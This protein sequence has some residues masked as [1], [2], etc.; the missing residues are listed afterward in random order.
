M[1]ERRSSRSHGTVKYSGFDDGNESDDDF[2]I[3][4]H[5]TKK[6]KSSKTDEAAKKSN[7][8][9]K[10]KSLN[11][12]RDVVKKHVNTSSQNSAKARRAPLSEKIYERELQEA[13]ELSLVETGES[14]DVVNHGLDNSKPQPPETLTLTADVEITNCGRLA[15][16]S[17]DVSTEPDTQKSSVNTTTQATCSSRYAHGTVVIDESIELA[18]SESG[19]RGTTQ[20]RPT[21]T[22]RDR[23]ARKKP[24]L[25]DK[26]DKSSD[27][28]D[29]NPGDNSDEDE[30]SMC[31]TDDDDEETRRKVDCKSKKNKTA[32]QKTKN[33]SPVI[34]SKTSKPIQ[35]API[36]GTRKALVKSQLPESSRLAAVASSSTS[37]PCSENSPLKVTTSSAVGNKPATTPASK[38][39]TQ[40]VP[41]SLV[42]Q[43]KPPSQ[44]SSTQA[45]A[46]TVRSPSSGLRL[47]LSRNQRVKPL[48]PSVQ[49]S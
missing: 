42:S 28:S 43:W 3:S 12:D 4:S 8:S 17:G 36:K 24:R 9:I 10:D 48:H 16:T 15:S 34:A 46:D 20:Q 1:T 47:G 5:S 45:S 31:A 44:A 29:F 6:Q 13:L 25:A 23:Q 39:S 26:H 21:H 41:S 19:G 27:E 33:N 37:S 2:A 7:K 18:G 14:H 30:S 49:V 38:L 22:A 11:L 32:N 40:R 35:R